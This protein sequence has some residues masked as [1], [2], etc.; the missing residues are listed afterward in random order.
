VVRTLFGQNLLALMSSG[1]PRGS[2]GMIGVRR[3]H[4][5]RDDGMRELCSVRTYFSW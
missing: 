2:L 1:D 3:G 4:E 5:E